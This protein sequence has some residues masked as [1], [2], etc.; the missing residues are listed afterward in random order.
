MPLCRLAPWKTFLI[1][2]FTVDDP[3]I[4]AHFQDS[5]QD[6]TPD[7]ASLQ[8]IA[9]VLKYKGIA[10]QEP[11]LQEEFAIRVLLDQ[12]MLYEIEPTTAL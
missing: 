11:A 12:V 7:M 9:N 4:I 3:S 1:E 8:P 5:R 2:F 10:L 6:I